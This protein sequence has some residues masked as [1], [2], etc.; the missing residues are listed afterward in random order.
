MSF[1][2][3]ATERGQKLQGLLWLLRPLS[4]CCFSNDLSEVSPWLQACA[5]SFTLLVYFKP[6]HHYRGP[7]CTTK[8]YFPNA[9]FCN[10]SL[11]QNLLFCK[12]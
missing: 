10:S 12:Y 9:S 5:V 3:F 8:A 11:L 4:L 2:A 6:A 7:L 1:T